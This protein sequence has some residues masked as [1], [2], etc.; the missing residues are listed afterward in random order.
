MT[1]TEIEEFKK[2]LVWFKERN[3]ARKWNYKY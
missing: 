3:S 1:V 2:W